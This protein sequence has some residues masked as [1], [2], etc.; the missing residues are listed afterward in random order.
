MCLGIMTSLPG[1]A[2][3]LGPGGQRGSPGPSTRGPHAITKGNSWAM[4]LS[5]RYDP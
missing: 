2:A 3:F 5:I 4:V 1:S